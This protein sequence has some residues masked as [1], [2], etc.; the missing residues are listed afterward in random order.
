MH[1][2]TKYASHDFDS[3]DFLF[4]CGFLT[5]SAI[6]ICLNFTSAAHSVFFLRS[7]LRATQNNIHTFSPFSLFII[8]KKSLSTLLLQGIYSSHKSVWNASLSRKLNFICVVY[9]RDYIEHNIRAKCATKSAYLLHFLPVTHRRQ[10]LHT[11]T[12]TKLEKNTEEK[13]ISIHMHAA[14]LL[15]CV[16][17]WAYY[18]TNNGKA[19][20]LLFV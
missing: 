2:H 9:I 20:V 19:Y 6:R 8:S 1:L 7:R 14:C 4:G 10:L 11:H 3:K 16:H 15:P 18:A 5:E 13:T 17:N 12:H